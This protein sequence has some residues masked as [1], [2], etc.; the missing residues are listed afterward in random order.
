MGRLHN[1]Q[2]PNV[3]AWSSLQGKVEHQFTEYNITALFSQRHDAIVPQIYPPP[4]L[5][6]AQD[7]CNRPHMPQT[8]SANT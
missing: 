6:P 7:L 3:G 5:T 8:A 1:A 4:D 2:F